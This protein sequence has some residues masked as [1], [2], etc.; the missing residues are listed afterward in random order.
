MSGTSEIAGSVELTEMHYGADT[1]GCPV[2][3]ITDLIRTRA[4]QIFEAKG[5]QQGHALD[6]WLQAE[7][8]IKLHFDL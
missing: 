7:H 3:C 5:R 4:Y 8:E 1:S 6:D 2:K